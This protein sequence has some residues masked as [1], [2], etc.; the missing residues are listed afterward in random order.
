MR[1]PALIERILPECPATAAAENPGRSVVATSAVASPSASTGH[2]YD[3]PYWTTEGLGDTCWIS[4][5][6]SDSVA[7]LDTTTGEE[8]AYREVGDHPQRVRHGYVPEALVDTW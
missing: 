8:L 4:L 6:G 1:S 3:K 5:S 7:V 2:A